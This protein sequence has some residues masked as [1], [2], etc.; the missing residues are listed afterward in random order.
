M[1]CIFDASR[2]VIKDFDSEIKRS[3]FGKFLSFKFHNH[4]Y[5]RSLKNRSDIETSALTNENMDQ[6]RA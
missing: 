6:K 2:K 4:F 5:V 1:K 3:F